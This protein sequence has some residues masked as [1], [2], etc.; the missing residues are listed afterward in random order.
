MIEAMVGLLFTPVLAKPPPVG[1][2]PPPT[3][4][5]RQEEDPPRRLGT[6]IVEGTRPQDDRPINMRPSIPIPPNFGPLPQRPDN[7]F[8]D[9]GE[10]I[11]DCVIDENEVDTKVQELADEI[12]GQSDWQQREY[13]AWIWREADGTLNWTRTLVPL[14][15]SGGTTRTPAQVTAH[16]EAQIVGWIHNQNPGPTA[17]PQHNLNNRNPS[18]ADW[19]TYDNLITGGLASLDLSLYLIG[20]DG[21]L[22][23]FN[24]GDQARHTADPP[25]GFPSLPNENHNVRDGTCGLNEE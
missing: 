1:T 4:S 7:N 16:G 6:V 12:K 5:P 24:D 23:E 10:T 2:V 25:H 8:E 21:V 11:N 18:A 9:F 13:V 19:Q 14:T 22:H 20:T 15:A 17:T 3:R